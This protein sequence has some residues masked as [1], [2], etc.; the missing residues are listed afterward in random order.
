MSAIAHL[1]ND[2]KFSG[3]SS[4]R[5]W[6][7]DIP[8]DTV[9]HVM[10]H[11]TS[12]I[13]KNNENRMVTESRDPNNLDHVIKVVTDHSPATGIYTVIRDTS[14]PF[15][16]VQISQQIRRQEQ[17]ETTVA[18]PARTRK[19]KAEQLEK[20]RARTPKPNKPNKPKK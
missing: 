17:H 5:S 14:R 4:S 13:S 8:W 2:P 9:K 3:H 19:N 12:T 20:K 6:E 7:R 1:L 10:L 16:D 15:K 11:G 18:K